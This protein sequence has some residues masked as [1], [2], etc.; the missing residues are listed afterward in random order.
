MAYEVQ[1]EEQIEYL[2]RYETDAYRVKGC[3]IKLADGR[4]L[5]GKTFIWNA[6]DFHLEC[7]KGVIEGRKFRS[8]GLADRAA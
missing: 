1:K 6:G 8:K 3:K 7:R 4:E 2:M 5:A